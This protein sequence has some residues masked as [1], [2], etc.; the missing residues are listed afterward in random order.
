M[1]ALFKRLI[2]V[3]TG[4]VLLTA[5]S[6][7]PSV[8]DR[9]FSDLQSMWTDRT[10]T[11]LEFQKQNAANDS[12]SNSQADQNKMTQLLQKTYG[13]EWN[14]MKKYVG[15]DLKDDTLTKNVKEYLDALKA[16]NDALNGEPS[17]E[18]TKAFNENYVKRV[19]A[20]KALGED[21]RFTLP[22]DQLNDLNITEETLKQN[23]ARDQR[24]Q[25]ASE[26]FK[27]DLEAMKLDITKQPTTQDPTATWS[28]ELTNHSDMEI[29]NLHL[30]FN[31]LDKADKPLDTQKVAIDTLSPGETKKFSI[32]SSTLNFDHMQVGL[33]DQ[34]QIVE[35]G[36]PDTQTSEASHKN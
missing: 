21:P 32:S 28:G 16:C 5:C 14:A 24:I 26:Q 22:K 20:L 31:L 9:F 36:T 34:L 25:K 10:K 3:L 2:L 15:Q 33:D 27:K 4:T 35:P 7:N 18:K 19:N 17:S 11:L 1:K 29:R 23:E 13:D 8:D 12:A 30:S 6:V